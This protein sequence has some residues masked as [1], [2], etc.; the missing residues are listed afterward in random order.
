MEDLRLRIVGLDV[1]GAEASKES[2]ESFV[3][4]SGGITFC[5]GCRPPETSLP[6][7]S[8]PVSWTGYFLSIPPEATTVF[9]CLDY[10]SPLSHT[11]NLSVSHL[12]N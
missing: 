4:P 5:P 6:V 1:Q 3:A 9:S 7:P 10:S 12:V 11:A 2:S 8:S